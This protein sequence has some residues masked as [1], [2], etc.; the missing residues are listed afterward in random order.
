M[1]GD[2]AMLDQHLF[3]K[4]GR[5]IMVGDILKVFHFIGRRRK[6]HYMYKQ[7]LGVVCLRGGSPCRYLKLS[8]L[9]LNDSD[10][11]HEH[12]DG[13][14]LRDYEIVQS[15]DAQFEDRPRIKDTPNVG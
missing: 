10:Y 7:V 13:R 15:I 6:R 12:L 8:H 3:D 2:A 4:T 5:E 11:Y 14:V 1:S 9:N